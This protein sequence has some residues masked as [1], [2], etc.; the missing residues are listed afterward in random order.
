MCLAV[1]AEYDQG[2]EMLTSIVFRHIYYVAFKEIFQTG[3]FRRLSD[4]VF[5]VHS[6]G[7]TKAMRAI[8]CSKMLKNLI[9]I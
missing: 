3:L 5:R 1:M 6:F 4:H 8:F 2:A 9:Y 7:N